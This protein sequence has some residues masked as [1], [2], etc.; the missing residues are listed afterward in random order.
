M[1]GQLVFRHEI[2]DAD[3]PGSHHDVTLLT[4]LTGNGRPDIII[5]GKYGENTLF[6][7]EDP[8][9]RRYEIGGVPDLEPCGVLFDVDGDGRVD[10]IVGQDYQGKELYWFQQPNDPR[11]P[12]PSYLI[13]NRFWK[14]HDQAIGDIDDDGE[15][16][17]IILSQKAGV[18]GYYDF[19]SEPQQ[20][21]WHAYFHLIAEIDDSQ[22]GLALA[23]L[24]HSGRLALIAG[25]NIYWPEGAEGWRIQAI[26]PEMRQT[27]CAAGDLNGD[28][29]LDIVLCE[30]ES[31]TG[32]LK[33][34]A[35]P[36]W[37]AHL[38]AEGLD[39]P[40]SLEIAD[41]D[42]DGQLDIMIGEMGLGDHH[43]PRIIVYRNKGGGEFEAHI[44]S[45]GIATH[46]AKVADMNG[47]GRLDIVGKAYQERHIDIWWNESY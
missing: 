21:P 35:G 4:D 42:G 10:I 45:E 47:D 8:G 13:E 16:E 30:G 41:F 7:Y 38:L 39:N 20:G 29:W 6:W 3:P 32:S 12:W 46:E 11:R 22:E 25:T 15:A 19:P 44:I 9:W 37:E 33:W 36:H 27:R 18:L 34:F 17:L 28:G 14:Y 24:D 2:I 31:P 1:R 26:A 23:D 43:P 40:H 5:G